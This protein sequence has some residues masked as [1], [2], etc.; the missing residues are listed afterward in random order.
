MHGQEARGLQHRIE[1][2]ATG[3]AAL[4][5]FIAVTLLTLLVIQLPNSH[6]R[7]KTLRLAQPYANAVGLDQDWAVFAPDPRRVV[8]GVEARVTFADGSS[9][10]WEP[11]RSNSVIGPYWD[12]R[13]MKYMEI[14][15]QDVRRQLWPDLAAYVARHERGSRRPVRVELTRR[16]YELFPPGGQGPLR[17]PWKSYTFFTLSEG[18]LRAQGVR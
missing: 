11:P 12:Y 17:S 5:A 8:I 15:R 14:V 4:S 1:G 3:R 10:L 2:S 7:Q 16:W 18:G 9:R 6:V 13:W